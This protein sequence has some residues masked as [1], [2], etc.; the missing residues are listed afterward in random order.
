MTTPALL[1]AEMPITRTRRLSE[2]AVIGARRHEDATIRP[3]SGKANY[4]RHR[5]TRILPFHRNA[6][7]FLYVQ[8]IVKMFTFIAQK[9]YV[10]SIVC[11]I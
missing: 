5:E 1:Y 9:F 6:E 10:Y 8:W 2:I 11:V 7:K 3:T 4:H